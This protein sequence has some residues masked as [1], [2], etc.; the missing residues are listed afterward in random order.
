M[1]RFFGSIKKEYCIST[2]AYH[3]KLKDLL[4]NHPKL[5]SSFKSKSFELNAKETFFFNTQ[6]KPIYTVSG[7]ADSYNEKTKIKLHIRTYFIAE[8]I[9]ISQIVG[10]L[11]ILFLYHYD[12]Y[13]PFLER[14][15][16][17]VNFATLGLI[18]IGIYGIYKDYKRK[19][20]GV[21]QMD[22]L[23]NQLD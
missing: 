20:K 21:L 7:I 8:I 23:F 17:F 10:G 12:N 4:I 18:A 11:I 16:K 9:S 5:E 19:Q 2:I 1:G 14:K 3:A 13:A 6:K 15:G 22:E